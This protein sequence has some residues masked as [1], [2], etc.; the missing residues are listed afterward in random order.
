MKRIRF[1]CAVAAVIFAFSTVMMQPIIGS[2]NTPGQ[3]LRQ[4]D[5]KYGKV[6]N[7]SQK[8]L[9]KMFDAEYYA[10][11]QPDVVKAFGKN[12]NALFKHFINTFRSYFIIFNV[13]A[14]LSN[15][16]FFYYAC[17]FSFVFYKNS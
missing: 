4:E 13:V 10:E 6:S 7:A 2:A 15:V 3:A 16:T 12:K 1:L 9:K 14:F 5:V 11:T 8:E 17:F